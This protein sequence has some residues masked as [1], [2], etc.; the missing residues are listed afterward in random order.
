MLS[1]LVKKRV[2]KAETISSG[3]LADSSI[4]AVSSAMLSNDLNNMNGSEP[5]STLLSISFESASFSQLTEDK[6]LA[7]LFFDDV[8]LS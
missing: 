8:C 5:S 2:T 4:A 6:K 3:S 7:G 1:A